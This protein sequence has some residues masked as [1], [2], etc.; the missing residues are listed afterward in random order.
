MS[1]NDAI[2]LHQT[3]SYEN[4]VY[5]LKIFKE[6]KNNYWI[7]YYYEQGYGGLNIDIEKAKKY[8][9]IASFEENSDA[10]YRLAVNII[11]YFNVND[12]DEEKKINNMYST[13][14][15]K[16][17]AELGHIDAAYYYGDILLN[18]KL[19]NEINTSVAYIYLSFAA[20]R[21]HIKAISLL[22]NSYHC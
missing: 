5:A 2:Q 3:R 6:L 14:L 16:K 19:D 18:G 10:I 8:Y 13:V 9:Q 20:S 17:S 1:L 4:R 11:N 21:S 7:G 22:E 12:S 15:L